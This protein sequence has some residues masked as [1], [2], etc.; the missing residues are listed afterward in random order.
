MMDKT[1]FG[2]P[3]KKVLGF[4]HIDSPSQTTSDLHYP[5]KS[6]GDTHIRFMGLVEGVTAACTTRATYAGNHGNEPL[7]SYYG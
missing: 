5:R 1:G 2:S 7:V 6:Q 3:L 4:L